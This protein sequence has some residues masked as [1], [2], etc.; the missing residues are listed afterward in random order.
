MRSIK[1]ISIDYLPFLANNTLTNQLDSV[2]IVPNNITKVL[3]EAKLEIIGASTATAN[4][5]CPA[6]SKIFDNL[7]Y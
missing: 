1:L 5:T 3:R 2:P 4:M 6:L 7:S